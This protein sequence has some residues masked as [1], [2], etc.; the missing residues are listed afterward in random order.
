LT[1]KYAVL[2]YGNKFEGIELTFNTK[3]GKQKTETIFEMSISNGGLSKGA[4]VSPLANVQDGLVNL[5]YTTMANMI[6]KKKFLKKF[7]DGKQIYD[8]K[9]EQLWL[10][11]VK[12]TNAEKKIKALVDGEI[13][14]FPQID[15]VVIE[16][17]LKIFKKKK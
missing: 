13:Q 17:G 15:I 6:E 9:I 3:G 2:K 11:S 14:I 4:N 10:N 16:N 7:N 5:N 12:I 1:Q 8:E